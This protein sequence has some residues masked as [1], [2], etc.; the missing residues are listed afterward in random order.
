MARLGLV[1][2]DFAG[3]SLA[4]ALF[5]ARMGFQL[6]HFLLVFGQGLVTQAHGLAEQGLPCP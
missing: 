2:L 6:G 4:E 3:T 1:P 5:R